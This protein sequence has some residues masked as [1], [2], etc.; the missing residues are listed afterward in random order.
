MTESELQNLLPDLEPYLPGQ[1]AKWQVTV[2]SSR[3]GHYLLIYIL[4]GNMSG[5]WILD[6]AISPEDVRE[7]GVRLAKE[8]QGW[9]KA[10]KDKENNG[11]N[12]ERT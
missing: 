2:H 8:A 11:R 4:A 7:I 3:L 9:V 10:I 12:N 5:G 6:C 1:N